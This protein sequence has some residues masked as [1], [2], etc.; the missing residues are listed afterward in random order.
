[1]GHYAWANATPV[2]PGLDTIDDWEE[3]IDNDNNNDNDND[4]DSDSDSDNDGT[5]HTPTNAQDPADEDDNVEDFLGF[6]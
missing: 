5:T 4:S 2:I 3:E 1:M 6:I